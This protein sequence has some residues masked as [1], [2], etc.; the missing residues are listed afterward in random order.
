MPALLQALA[1]SGDKQ[2]NLDTIERYAAV[3]AAVGA[4]FVC[5]PELFLTGYNLGAALC[6]MAE[7]VDGTSVRRLS[8]IA[9]RNSIGL[10][11]G[12]PERD[13]DRIYNSAVAVDGQGRLVGTC[14]KIQLFGAVEPEIF[15]PG[16]GLTIVNMGQ[17]RLGILICYDVEFP[18]LSRALVRDGAEIICAPT[19]N[20]MPYLEVPKTL[21]RARALENGIPFVYANL[22]GREENL[23]YTGLSAI[24]G[25]DGV[26]RARAGKT[27]EAFLHASFDDLAGLVADPLRSSQLLD[28]RLEAL[29]APQ[30]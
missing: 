11:V 14:R 27:G 8:E 1:A 25:F 16:Q 3:A 22:C 15:T 12:M 2:A 5:F 9:R 30:T 24:V 6:D 18:E 23:T 13:G 7:P 21:V 20:M 29:K 28:L 26:D 19:A 4:E 10:I 17:R